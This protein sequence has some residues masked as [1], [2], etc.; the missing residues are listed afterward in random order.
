MFGWF[1]Y[2]LVSFNYEEQNK[3]N[4]NCVVNNDE[5]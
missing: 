5:N 2:M 1:C 4:V 3:K